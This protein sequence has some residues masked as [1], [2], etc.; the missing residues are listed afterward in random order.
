[1]SQ[2]PGGYLSFDGE[3]SA[4]FGSCIARGAEQEQQ[5]EVTMQATDHMESEQGEKDSGTVNDI[6]GQR[7][8]VE[9]L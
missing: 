5:R 8:L 7:C 9:G 6:K 2:L 3:L 4:P 1:M